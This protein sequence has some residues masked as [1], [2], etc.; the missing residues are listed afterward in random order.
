M[1]LTRKA[2][3]GILNL[4]GPGWDCVYVACLLLGF[5]IHFL[6]MKFFLFLDHIF[7]PGF[8]KVDVK[9]PVFIIGHPRSGTTFIHHLFSQT[10]ETAAFKAWHLLFPSLTARV[11]VRPV[12]DFMIRRNHTDLIPKETGHHIA[13]DKPE[14]EEM[15]FLHNQDTQFITAITPLGF[16]DDDF[17]DMRFHD[18]QPDHMRLKSAEFLKSCFQRQIYYSGNSQIFAQTHYSTHRI[19]TLMDVFPDAKFLYIDRAPEETLPSYF[20]LIHNVMDLIWGLHRFSSNDIKRF[21]EYRYSASLELYRYFHDLHMNGDIDE[22]TVM[23]IPYT[24]LRDDLTGVFERIISFTGIK[25][26]R[27]LRAA[28][29]KQAEKQK[30]YRR[31]HEVRSISEFGIDEIRVRNDFSFCRI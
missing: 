5:K 11:L 28:V 25:P 7:F 3:E 18:L 1:K 2:L 4:L 15:L 9:K 14:E 27:E 8:H 13:L 12:V 29:E 20:S 21:F 23:I 26:S 30:Q 22:N 10:D 6:F 19:K 17:R 16:L 31:E 24:E